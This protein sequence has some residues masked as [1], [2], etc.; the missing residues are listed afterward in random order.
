MILLQHS[1]WVL[2][3]ILFYIYFGYP[4]LLFILS[5]LFMTEIER[6]PFKPPVSVLIAAYNEE[7]YIKETIENKL[8]LNYPKDRLEIIVISDGSTD[9]TDEIVKQFSKKNVKLIRQEPRNGK[10][11][12]LNMAVPEAKGE[13]IVFSDA[14]SIYDKDAL[15]H[16][17]QNFADPRVGY[18]TGRMIYTNP[19]GTIIGDGC[20]AYMKYE[21]LI[22]KHETRIGSVVGVDG[23]IDA[24]RK[25]L[26]E[27]MR[28]DQLPDFILPLMVVDKAYRVI[29]E[30]N[31]ILK[32]QTLKSPE[33]EYRMRVRVTLRAFWA[34]FDMKRLFNPLRSGS[35]A[36]QIISHK[37]LRYTAFFFLFSLFI[38]NAFLLF[39]GPLYFSAFIVQLISYSLAYLGRIVKSESAFSKITYFPFYFSLLNIAAAKAFTKFLKGEKQAIW[40]PRVG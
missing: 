36:L 9:G 17:M 19:D 12:A 37:V 32:E 21:N 13:I 39:Q 38:V 16:M 8:H 15:L 34:L 4:I 10:T 33:D 20:S 27:P 40:Q 35:Y 7:E 2:F 3:F 31:A 22:R 28:I 24:V 26:Y 18:V 14:N 1:F 29:Y 6:V 30:P 23:G 11:A 5:K 25:S